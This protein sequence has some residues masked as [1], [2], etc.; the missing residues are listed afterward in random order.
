[1]VK[2]IFLCH[3]RPDITHERYVELLLHGHVPLALRH[4]PTL[5]RY[6]VNIVEQAPPTEA[7]IDSIGALWFDTID[8]YRQRLYDSPEGERIVQRDVGGFLGG[9]HAYATT[10]YVQKAAAAGQPGQR[11]PGVTMFCP[12]RRRPD[13]SHAEFVRHWQTT[14]V[15]LALAHHPHMVRYVTNVVDQRLDDTSPDWDGFAE[16]AFANSADA[17]ERLFGSPAGERIVRDDIARFIGH[18]FAYLVGE[19]VQ[20]V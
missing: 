7:A 17:R 4:H 11:T 15:P 6:T 1:M 3:R 16:I 13:L 5:R 9:A 20:R 10:E 8:D 18:T 12:L 14:H 2:V 19:Y